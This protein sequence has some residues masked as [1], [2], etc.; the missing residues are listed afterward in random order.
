MSPVAHNGVRYYLDKMEQNKLYLVWLSSKDFSKL[1]ENKNQALLKDVWASMKNELFIYFQ[2]QQTALETITGDFKSIWLTLDPK[3]SMQYDAE[4][5][6]L[7]Y[8]LWCLFFSLGGDKGNSFVIPTPAWKLGGELVHEHDHFLFLN[9]H[10]MIGKGKDKSDD[11]KEKHA[12]EIEKK[13]YSRQLDFLSKCKDNVPP[14][15][16]TYRIEKMQWARDGR[17]L[18]DLSTPITKLTTEDMQK[19]IEQAIHGYSE[20]AREVESGGNYDDSVDENN[21]QTNSEMERIM[22]LPTKLDA[23][24]KGYPKIEMEM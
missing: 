17:P 14:L 12:K 1:N 7:E 22:S 10:D 21:V 8:H 6:T 18:T 11:F 15:T 16:L 4:Q 19:S 5:N 9:E 20:V 13:A 3:I 23:K 2:N 24:K